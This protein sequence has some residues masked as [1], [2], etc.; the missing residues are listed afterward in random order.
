ME[1]KLLNPAPNMP[2]TDYPRP[3][4]ARKDWYCLNGEWDFSYYP[5]LEEEELMQI[6]H[7]GEFAAQKKREKE[8]LAAREEEAQSTNENSKEEVK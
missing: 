2:R 8:A 1:T 4:W 3:Q 5:H 7:T 6:L